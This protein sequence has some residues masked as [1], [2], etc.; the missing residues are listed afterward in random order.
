MHKAGRVTAL[1]RDL[2]PLPLSEGLTEGMCHIGSIAELVD[3]FWTAI[4]N[5]LVVDRRGE[6]GT[7]PIGHYT[8]KLQLCQHARREEQESKEQGFGC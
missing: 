3:H 5:V 8:H 1:R 6:E 2:H 4:S 7:K